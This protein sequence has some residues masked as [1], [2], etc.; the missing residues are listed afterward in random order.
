MK[1]LRWL[2]GEVGLSAMEVEDNE[3]VTVAERRGRV[4]SDG[5]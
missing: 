2:R 3:T 5:G 1:L 4:V